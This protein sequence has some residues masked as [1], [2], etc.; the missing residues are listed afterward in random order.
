[1]S[2]PIQSD[3]LSSPGQA[4][5][6]AG[7]TSPVRGQVDYG[8]ISESWR[9]FT[10][11]IGPWVVATLLLLAPVIVFYIAYYAYMLITILPNGFAP[12]PTPPVG[13][14]G[15]PTGALSPGPSAAKM[16]AQ[17][18]GLIPYAIGF[19]L[20]FSL[21]AA[22]LYGGMLRMAVRQVRGLPVE[23]KDIFRGGP[24]FGRMLGAIFLL[25]FGAYGLEA[26]CL[27]P[28]GI[29]TWRHGPPLA[30]GL[31]AAVGGILLFALALLAYSLLI[32]A[33]ALMADGVG[34]FD[35][36]KRSVKAM[37]GQAA[38]GAGFVFV[39]GLLVYASQL[40]CGIGTLAT[41]PM[42]FLIT[43]LAYRDMVGMPNMAPL[44][45]PVYAPASVGVWPPPPSLPVSPAFPSDRV[46]PGD[47]VSPDEKT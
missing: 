13:A 31:T 45:G 8:W 22:Y 15:L 7:P 41:L 36:L 19:G 9:L 6:A 37:K 32:P 21:W 33:F 39:F 3:G 34:V 42:G 29:V 46:V 23:M 2:I 12:P 17:M 24:L 40:L 47:R 28:M 44:P 4:A 16:N 18:A 5:A 10:A 27:G 35:A 30:I 38:A 14:T 26:L 25:G 20:L 1:M 11:Q 43:A